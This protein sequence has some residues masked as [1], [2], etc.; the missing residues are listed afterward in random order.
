MSFR[1]FFSQ[2]AVLGGINDGSST[3]ADGGSFDLMGDR[4]NALFCAVC[5]ERGM[6]SLGCLRGDLEGDERSPICTEILGEFQDVAGISGRR[7]PTDR[8][9]RYF[10]ACKSVSRTTGSGTFFWRAF[11]AAPVP[12]VLFFF[13]GFAHPL[14]SGPRSE[15][16][17]INS[18]LP[19]R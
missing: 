9:F 15:E 7:V 4:R 13:H 12:R 2:S 14:S 17:R 5:P 3:V 11:T 16:E 6:G 8:S 10:G 1:S 19:C 18:G